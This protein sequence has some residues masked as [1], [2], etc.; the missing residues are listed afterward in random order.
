MESSRYEV[1]PLD[2]TWKRFRF[3]LVRH[4]DDALV[5]VQL[6]VFPEFNDAARA[7]EQCEA[8]RVERVS[9]G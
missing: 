5:P 8:A 1:R 9:I 7:R 3:E 4:D 2:D 6:G